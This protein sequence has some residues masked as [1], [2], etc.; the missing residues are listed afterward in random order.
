MTYTVPGIYET[1]QVDVSREAG[2]LLLYSDGTRFDYTVP[3]AGR[4]PFA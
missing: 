3:D 1:A 2:V 4:T